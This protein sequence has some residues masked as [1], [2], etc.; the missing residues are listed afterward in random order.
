VETGKLAKE[1]GSKA[2]V[3]RTMP[4]QAL[5]QNE[6]VTAICGGPGATKA[7]L[8]TTRKIFAAGGHVLEVEEEQM[9]AVTALSGSCPSF[10]AKWA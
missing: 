5:R 3:V 2:R 9:D 10:M 7:D 6:G 8:E 1:A 4:N